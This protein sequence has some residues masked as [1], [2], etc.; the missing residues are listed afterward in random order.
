MARQFAKSCPY[1]QK[2]KHPGSSQKITP[3]EAAKQYEAQ[4]RKYVTAK[5]P[6]M[7]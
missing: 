2:K 3:S 5:I 1:S 7:L 6:L 4:I